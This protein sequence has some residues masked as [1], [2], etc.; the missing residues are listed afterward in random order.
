MVLISLQLSAKLRMFI[1]YWVLIC[2]Q[3]LNVVVLNKSPSFSL[4]TYCARCYLSPGR[5]ENNYK[6]L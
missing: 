3:Q 4:C 2:V 1:V 5:G 6:F